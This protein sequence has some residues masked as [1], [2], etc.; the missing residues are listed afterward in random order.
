MLH[1]T[2]GILFEIHPMAMKA[3]SMKTAI[4]L[5][6]IHIYI[7]IMI[8]NGYLLK[9]YPQTLMDFSIFSR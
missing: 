6:R 4:W 2:Y 7:I 8:G 3:L 1:F 5:P 9:K